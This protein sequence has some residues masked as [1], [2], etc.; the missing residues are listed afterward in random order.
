[1]QKNSIFLLESFTLL[2]DS[3]FINSKFDNVI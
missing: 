2:K 3:V 1:M